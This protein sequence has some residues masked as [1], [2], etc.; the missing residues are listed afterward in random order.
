MGLRG[1]SGKKE[2]KN[3]FSVLSWKA[4][5]KGKFFVFKTQ[6]HSSDGC[7]KNKKEGEFSFLC[8][9]KPYAPSL[10]TAPDRTKIVFLQKGRPRKEPVLTGSLLLDVSSFWHLSI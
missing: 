10:T 8:V 5:I 9:V 6:L 7:F 2:N 4:K 3:P 1:Y